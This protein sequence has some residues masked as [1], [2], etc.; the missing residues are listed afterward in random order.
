L[1]ILQSDFLVLSQFINIFFNFNKNVLKFYF[2]HFSCPPLFQVKGCWHWIGHLKIF[3]VAS[4]IKV[5]DIIRINEWNLSQ[6]EEQT[7]N[8]GAATFSMTTF[9]IMTVST[10]KGP[11]CD[12]LHRNIL[13]RVPISLTLLCSVLLL[14]LLLCC[15]SL[16]WVSLY[17]ITNKLRYLYI[18]Y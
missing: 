1:L 16:C 5:D 15:L 9:R 11:I 17:R 6:K 10:Y 18:F 2:K 13:R 7:Q 12:T 3:F 14:Y 8:F 4:S